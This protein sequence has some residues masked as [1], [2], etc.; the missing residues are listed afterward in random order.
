MNVFTHNHPIAPRLPV[1]PLGTRPKPSRL[2]AALAVLLL[3]TQLGAASAAPNPTSASPSA[4]PPS[5]ASSTAPSS[6]ASGDTAKEAPLSQVLGAALDR[7][8]KCWNDGDLE[9]FMSGYI[10]DTE[11]DK[12]L[13]DVLLYTSGGHEVHGYKTLLERYQKR[14]GKSKSSMGKLRFGDIDFMRLGPD[15]AMAVGHWFVEGANGRSV[16]GT[17]T[18]LWVETSKGWKIFHDHTSLRTSP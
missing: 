18:L 4:S 16:D 7:Q 13:G 6:G 3:L 14:Y 12:V 17:F 5:A 15:M 10:D 2:G 8:A 1:D 11:A 9:G